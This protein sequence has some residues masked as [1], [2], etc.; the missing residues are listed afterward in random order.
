MQCSGWCASLSSLYSMCQWQDKCHCACDWTRGNVELAS[1]GCYV[2]GIPG[3]FSNIADHRDI[4]KAS[5]TAE[6]SLGR[7][8]G[9]DQAVNAVGKHCRSIDICLL[10]FRCLSCVHIAQQHPHLCCAEP[11]LQGAM[12]S[13]GQSA[14]FTCAKEIIR[15]QACTQAG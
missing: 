4:E 6:L 3:G 1:T 12:R 7:S 5:L 15:A 11:A 9:F 10:A 14:T 2:S 13:F 8:H